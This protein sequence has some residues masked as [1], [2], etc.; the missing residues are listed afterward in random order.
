VTSCLG[1]ERATPA[2]AQDMPCERRRG[3]RLD[4]ESRVFRWFRC[5][6]GEGPILMA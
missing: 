3:R 4:R 2:S 6:G 5:R 1:G